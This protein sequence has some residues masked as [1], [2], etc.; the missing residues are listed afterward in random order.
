MV[1]VRCYRCGFAFTLT[2]Q[3]ISN[4]LAAQGIAEK[5]T[6]YSTECP[7]CRHINKVSLA[8]VTLPAAETPHPPEAPT[9]E[10]A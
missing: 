10:Q 8:R 5:P 6:H 2:E 3:H 1:K 7:R 9:E 4:M